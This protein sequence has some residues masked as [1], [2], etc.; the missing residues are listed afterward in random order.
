MKFNLKNENY[1]NFDIYKDNVLQPRSYFIPFSSIEEA[2][3]SDIRTERYNSSMVAVLSGEWDFKYF[4]RVSDMPDEIDID[5]FEFDTVSV[6]S[7]WQHTGYEEPYY[8]N[9]RYQF[10]PNPPEIP[11]DCPVG[12]YHK[13]FNLDN[14]DGNFTLTF[15]GVAGALDIF[16]NGSY[17]GYSEGSHNTSEFELNEFVAKGKN[18]LVVV[19]HKWSNGT[20]LE[21]QDMFRNNGIFRDVLLTK[22]GNNSI[23]DFEVK[24]SF[25]DD[26]TYDLTIIPSLK[27]TDECE[28]TATII[29]DEVVASK[30][31]NVSADSID[32]LEFKG[33]NVKEWSAEEPNLYKLVLSLA[34]EGKAVEVIVKNIGF[35]HIKINGN[36][37]TFNNKP[38]KLLGVNH[39]DTNPK[40]GYVMTVSDMEKDI[41]IFKEYNVNCVRTSHYP[42]DPIFLDLCDEYG[43]YVV[44]EADIEA[45][46]CQT[47]LHKP[48]AC[49]HKP[50]WQSRYWDRVYRMFE[51][52]KNHPSITMWSL[53]NESWGYLNQ[54]YCYEQLKKLSP[55]PVHYENVVRTKRFAYDVIS[56]MYPWHN[57]FSKL[58]KGRGLPKKYYAKPYYMC[59]YAHAM[60]LGAGE[61]ETYVNAFLHADNLMGGCIWEFADHAVYHEN[62]KYKYTYGGDHGEEK[63][64]GNFCVDGLFFPDRTPHAGALQMKNCYRP[65][66]AERIGDEIEFFNYK[67]FTDAKLT[68]KW[69]SLTENGE[70]DIDIKPRQS[71]KVN[72]STKNKNIVLRYFDNDFEVASEQLEYSAELDNE[73]YL[74][75]KESAPSVSISEKKLYVKFDGGQLIYNTDTGA[76]ESYERKGNEFINSA[77]FSPLS[78]FNATVFRAPIDNDM[79]IKMAW[80]RYMLETEQMSLVNKVTPQKSYIIEKNAVVIKNLYRLSTIKT[81]SLAKIEIAYT[82]YG[83]GDVKVDVKCKSSKMIMYVPRFG[84]TFE[85]PR[86]YDNVKYFGLGE[87]PNTADFKEHAMLGVYESKVDDMREKYIKPQESSMRSDVW[88]AEIT[89][90]N[91]TGLRFTAIDK[92][93]TFGADHFTSQQCAKAMHQ[94]DLKLCDTTLLHLDSY[95]LGAAS[96]ACGP[97]PGKKYRLNSIKGQQFSFMVSPIDGITGD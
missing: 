75:H 49:S 86:K 56:E 82:I 7:V 83:N 62:G 35:K 53:G 27:L 30:S 16:V 43:I 64:D 74:V 41:K 10:K 17:V 36:I 20:Y 72:L 39:H 61:L 15:L 92:P 85:M 66:R 60:G 3:K 23:Y 88:Y 21:A 58:A 80:K 40:T 54:D 93:F 32:K 91:G 77:P 78:G 31:V 13:A 51:R 81:R 90:D 5:S 22:T 1:K 38:I 73:P 55:I 48:G 65:V 37:F 63:H 11:A 26:Y 76:I 84:L 6:P 97:I 4:K 44:D 46:G 19:N 70:F 25:N 68:V 69:N 14:T 50:A 59:E 45:H 87:R 52:D 42:P 33:L 24:T 34:R 95:M 96:G 71:Q 89:D 12:I 79:Y 47:E 29:D 9:T 2:G 94:E 57:K 18:D 67:Y 8:L 28:L